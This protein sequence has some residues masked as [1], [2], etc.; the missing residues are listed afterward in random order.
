MDYIRSFKRRGCEIV[1]S[2]GILLWESEGKS[3]EKC[4]VKF[5]K[6]NKSDI[7]ILYENNNF[8]TNNMC[9]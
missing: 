4:V 6:D 8:K 2:N 7:E 5:L 9:I 3:P 1:G